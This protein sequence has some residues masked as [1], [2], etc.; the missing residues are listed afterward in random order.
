LAAVLLLGLSTAS[1]ASK[2]S[3]DSISK[4]TTSSVTVR[5]LYDKYASKK[6]DIVVSI[7]NK[8]TDK[9]TQQTFS[10]EKLSST[11]TKSVKVN[12]L[13]SGTKYSFKVKIRKHTNGNYSSW[14]DSQTAKTKS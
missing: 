1:A 6:V 7:R 11:G 10:N 12:N 14:S 3:I 8:D 2:P 9:T 13:L 4:K 5:V